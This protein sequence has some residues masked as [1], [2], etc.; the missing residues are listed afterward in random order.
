MY[1]KVP[2]PW[3][4]LIREVLRNGVLTKL[5]ALDKYPLVANPLTVDWRVDANC[6]VEIYPKVPNP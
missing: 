6:V 2:N 5:D 1:P 4:V 3:A